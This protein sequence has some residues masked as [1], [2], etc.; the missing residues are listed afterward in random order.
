MVTQKSKVARIT[1]IM[2]Q[3]VLSDM[4]RPKIRYKK[5]PVTLKDRC[6]MQKPGCAASFRNF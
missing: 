5:R 6:S 1:V 4:K 3:R 2:K